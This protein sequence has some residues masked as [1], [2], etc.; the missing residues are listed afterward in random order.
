M[1]VVIVGAGGQFGREVQRVGKAWELHPFRHADLD[2]C[3]HREVRRRLQEIDPGLVINAAAFTAVDACESEVDHAFQVNAFAVRNLAQVCREM[4]SVLVHL[5]TDYVFD[6]RAGTPYGEG[7]LPNPLNVY[8]VSKLT[9]EF[10][11]R[12]AQPRHIIL[13]TSGLYGAP[14]RQ[15]SDR[16]FVDTMLALAR[17]RDRI[18]VVDDQV[19]AP[20]YAWDLAEAMRELIRAESYGLYHVT[21]RGQCSWFAFAEAIFEKMGLNPDMERISSEDLGRE[22]Q[23]PSYSVLDTGKARS[24]MGGE[25]PP[26]GDALSRYLEARKEACSDG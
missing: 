12:Q 26:W 18:R 19:L 10:F 25:L 3:H 16:N 6:G 7:D 23:R 9:G 20:T 4:G 22:A 15:G 14:G 8:G 11:V 24:V 2:I 1:R 5:S 17:D 13:R 21:N